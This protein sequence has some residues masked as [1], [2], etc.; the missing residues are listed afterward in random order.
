MKSK[1]TAI[2]R[3]FGRWI[4]VSAVVAV[5][6]ILA[7]PLPLDA[8]WVH[9]STAGTP[10][11]ADGSPDLAAP[12]PRTADGKPDL[13]GVWDVEHNQPC[14]PEGCADMPVGREFGNIGWSLK[15]G[16]PYQPWAADLV[17]ARMAK[18]GLEDLITRCLPGGLV[19]AHTIP[20][21]RKIIQ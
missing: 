4:L 6:T 3:S 13:S 17:K 8:Q 19:H 11:K 5:I 10:R 20:L 7:L 18:N 12:T 21:F 2:D 1:V 14:A 9:L 15:D 16:L